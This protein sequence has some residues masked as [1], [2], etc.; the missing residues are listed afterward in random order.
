MDVKLVT[1]VP[2]SEGTTTTAIEAMACGVPVIATDV[3][4]VGEVVQDGVTGYLVTPN[5]PAAIAAKSLAL[6]RDSGLRRDMGNAGR[7]RAVK[8][9]DIA[10]CVGAH[11][12]AFE[13]A[14]RRQ[15][16]V[17]SRL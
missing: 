12:E 8:H 16:Q 1:S 9:F 14:F 15:K 10:T 11:I 13:L 17:G 4:A 3:G 2:R 5:D 7:E 6:L